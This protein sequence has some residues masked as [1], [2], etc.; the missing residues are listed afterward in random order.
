MV[1]KFVIPVFVAMAGI[2]YLLAYGADYC[3]TGISSALVGLLALF[4]LSLF[5]CATRRTFCLKGTDVLFALFLLVY[6][7]YAL[8]VDGTPFSS[9]R[10]IGWMS[11]GMLYYC[12]RWLGNR[13]YVFALLFGLAVVEGIYGMLQWGGVLPSHHFYFPATG[14]FFNPAGTGNRQDFLYLPD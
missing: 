1:R 7:F 14:S 10:A 2:G 9:Q 4:A 13:Q 5:A 11:A 12:M 6:A 8:V 3:V